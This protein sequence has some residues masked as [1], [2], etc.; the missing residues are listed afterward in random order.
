[1][2]SAARGSATTVVTIP[3]PYNPTGRSV[4]SWPECTTDAVQTSMADQFM[5]ARA[6]PVPDIEDTVVVDGC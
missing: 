4:G 5:V 6:M 3:T 1:M 2:S